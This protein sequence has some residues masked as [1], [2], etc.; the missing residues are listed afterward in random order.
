MHYRFKDRK[1]AGR[2]L[3]ERLMTF[4]GR[5][6]AV[7]LA[8]P[9]GGVPVAHEIAAVLQLPLDLMVVRKLGIPEDEE[10]AF[11]AL[12][13]TGLR[14]INPRL[15]EEFA[16]SARALAQIVALEQREL[17]R[18]ER[19]YRQGRPPLDLHGK[20]ALLVD[21]GIATGATMRVAVATA[22]EA[23]ARRVVVVA[24][25][26]AREAYLELRP[27]ADEVCALQIP[28]EFGAVG[29]FYVNFPQETDA[30]VLTLLEDA[31][32]HAVS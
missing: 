5:D 10:L 24:P 31:A 25:V 8:L 1:A 28:K 18:R 22:R 2:A 17:E 23:G 19:V 27:K 9:R 14:V 4:A 15:M 16:V 20:I 3:A 13:P 6:D 7:V 21:D 26:V 30:H 11:G 29:E 32:V 12:G